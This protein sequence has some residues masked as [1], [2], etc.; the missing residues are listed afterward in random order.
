MRDMS[1]AQATL[2]RWG[3]SIKLQRCVQ[4]LTQ[5]D[6]GLRLDPPVLKSTVSRWEQGKAEPSLHHKIQIA[7]ALHLPPSLLFPMPT[8]RSAA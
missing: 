1:N 3:D 2:I 5:T 4:E 8:K 6:L 7:D